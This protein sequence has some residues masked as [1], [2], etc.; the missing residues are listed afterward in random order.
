MS[1]VVVG[2]VGAGDSVNVLRPYAFIDDNA[3]GGALYRVRVVG[4][5]NGT[6]YTTQ[7]MAV[8]GTANRGV[9]A[10]PTNATDLTMNIYPTA[11]RDVF[12]VMV[13]E[14]NQSLSYKVVNEQGQTLL[15]GKTEKQ[16]FSISIASLAAGNYFVVIETGKKKTTGRVVKL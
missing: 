8:N 5:Q 14:P 16:E 7:P 13:S 12:T 15:S 3:V 4:L 10:T 1:Y 9:H 2:M 6:R 11:T